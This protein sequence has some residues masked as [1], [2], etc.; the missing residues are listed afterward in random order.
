MPFRLKT[1]TLVVFVAVLALRQR[2]MSSS[3]SAAIVP[4]R[5]AGRG[6]LSL[7]MLCERGGAACL[8]ALVAHPGGRW[9][10]EIG[11]A[12]EDLKI[13]AGLAQRQGSPVGGAEREQQPPQLVGWAV[14]RGWRV[15][16]N[17]RAPSAHA[18]ALIQLSRKHWRCRKDSHFLEYEVAS[19]CS[20][21]E[22]VPLASVLADSWI[23]TLPWTIGDK[24][25]ARCEHDNRQGPQDWWQCLRC[26]SSPGGM[27]CCL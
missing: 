2:A 18:F 23:C 16:S 11:G 3:E 21:K 5:S 24:A 20:L 1:C 26:A 7:S 9:S 19:S 6:R 15:V 8:V 17:G 12:G 22:P 13:A 10:A 4:A 14:L 25:P 27:D